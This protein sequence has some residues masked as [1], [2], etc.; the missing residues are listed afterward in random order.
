MYGRSKSIEERLN[1]VLKL[2]RKG[3]H[4]T[5]TLADALGVSRPTISRCLAALRERG[6]GIR[7]VR[8]ADGWAF[9]ITSD[10]ES[11]AQATGEAR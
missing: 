4:S 7:A 9:E 2:I 1:A 3:Q 11:A 6:H 8:N 5:P 10:S